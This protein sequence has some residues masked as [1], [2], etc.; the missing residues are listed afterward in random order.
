VFGPESFSG[1]AFL[2]PGAVERLITWAHR[3][4][5]H[6]E[7]DVEDQGKGRAQKRDL[8]A[9]HDA[10]ADRDTGRGGVGSG[11]GIRRILHA[12]LVKHRLV[13]IAPVPSIESLVSVF[14]SHRSDEVVENRWNDFCRGLIDIL[15]Y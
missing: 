3:S 14:R 9:D 12:G 1:V 2:S 10:A 8:R 4:A 11:N 7:H 6:L 5:D 15:S 13:S